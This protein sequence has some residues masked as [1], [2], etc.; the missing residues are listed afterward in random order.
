MASTTYDPVAA[1]LGFALAKAI[2][3]AVSRRDDGTLL[4]LS[5]VADRLSVHP[6]TVTKLVRDGDLPLVSVRGAKR[7]KLADLLAYEERQRS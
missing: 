1:T 7:V 4:K 5:E 2:E 6:N 3:D